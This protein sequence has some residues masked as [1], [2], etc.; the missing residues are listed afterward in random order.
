MDNNAAGR[1]ADKTKANIYD[2]AALAGVSYATV[3][4]YLNGHPNVSKSTAAR[5]DAAVA[6]TNYIP[7]ASAQSLARQRSHIVALIIHGESEAVTRDPNIMTIMATAN[8]RIA[9]EGWQMVTVMADGDT[10]VNNITRMIASGFA[11]GYI[12]FTLEKGDPILAA[13]DKRQIP[14]VI[15]GTGFKDNVP[16]PSVDVDNTSA[17]S[18]LIRHV[19]HPDPD[20]RRIHPAYISGPLNMPG[21]PERLTAFINTVTEEL[22]PNYNLPIS[23]NDDWLRET[24][25]AAVRRWHDSG[26]LD[27]VDAIVCANDTLAAGAV[28][29][30]HRLGR[31]VPE[32]IAVS[33]FDNSSAATSTMPQITTVDQH[34]EMRGEVLADIVIKKINGIDSPRTV[35]LPTELVVRQSA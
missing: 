9:Q 32:D 22:H 24:G 14:A 10:G 29:E 21:A 11:D 33:G 30:L 8:K 6:K 35:M 2:V 16:C 5:I 31:H 25:A 13:F 18:D 15:S 17:M 12:L 20:H 23:Y 34:M 4:R 27:G 3:S 28:E 1:T 7:S 19:L 26:V